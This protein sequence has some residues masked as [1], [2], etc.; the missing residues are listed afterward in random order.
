MITQEKNIKINFTATQILSGPV[1][2]HFYTED[3][4]EVFFKD[5]KYIPSIIRKGFLKEKI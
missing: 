5:K 4:R 3:G 1:D 2:M